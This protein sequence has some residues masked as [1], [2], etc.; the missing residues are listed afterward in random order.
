[1]RDWTEPGDLD[2]QIQMDDALRR[3]AGALGRWLR[4]EMGFGIDWGKCVLVALM[5]FAVLFALWVVEAIPQ[6]IAPVP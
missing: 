6:A 5:I 4:M 3:A 1:M 2:R